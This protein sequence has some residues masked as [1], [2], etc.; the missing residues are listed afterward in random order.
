MDPPHQERTHQA[1]I[2][3]TATST[4]NECEMDPSTNLT[5][6]SHGQKKRK[7]ATPQNTIDCKSQKLQTSDNS[8]IT[9]G[10]RMTMEKMKEGPMPVDSLYSTLPVGSD[11]HNL[12]IQEPLQ[13][14]MTSSL[15]PKESAASHLDVLLKSPDYR[16]PRTPERGVFVP[17]KTVPAILENIHEYQRHIT[18]FNA[19]EHYKKFRFTNL[20]CLPSFQE[21]LEAV[22]DAIQSLL[23]GIMHDVGL[24]DCVQLRLEGDSLTKSINSLQK[25]RKEINAERFLSY[26]A[27]V[28]QSNS[29]CLGSS[30]LT[31]TVTIVSN[32]YGGGK[33]RRS[34]KSICFSKIIEK[35]R[36]WLF[37]FQNNK[38]CFAASLIALLEEGSTDQQLLE[39]AKDLH[40][41]LGL[42]ENHMVNFNDI[43]LFETQLNVTINVLYYGQDQE[44]L[45]FFKGKV[46]WKD[47]ILYI[48]HHEEHYYGIKSIKSFLGADYFCK[49]CQSIFYH[50][51]NHSCKD[52]CKAC[53][54]RTCCQNQG[55]LCPTCRLFCRSEECLANHKIQA[56]GGKVKCKL[57]ACCE[58]CH[59]YYKEGSHH[60]CQDEKCRVC[61]DTI[62][63]V[64]DHLCYMTPYKVQEVDDNYIVYDIECTQDNQKHIPNYIY[65]KTLDGEKSWEF[66]DSSC[67]V[68]F[69]RFFADTKFK[70]YTFIA[71]NAGK[72]DS[73]F[74]LRQLIREKLEVRLMAKGGKLICVTVVALKIR[75]IDSINFLPMKLSKLPQA[76]GFAEVKG[77]FPHFFNTDDNQNYVGSLPPIEKYGADYMMPQEKEEFLKWHEEQK[78][79]NEVFDFQ[80]EL[81]KYC[82]QDVEILRQACICFRKRV[83]EMTRDAVDPFQ[84]PTLAS[85]CMAMYRFS[86][87]PAKTIAILPNDRYHRTK[88]RFSTPAIQWLMYVS[89]KEKINIQ[90]ALRGGEKKVGKYFLDGYALINDVHTAFEFLGCIYHGCPTCF[91][92]VVGNPIAKSKK[93]GEL[94]DKYERK[95]RY[96]ER[97]KFQVRTLWEHDW[98]EMVKND[99]EVK[100]FLSE[101]QYPQPLEPRDALYGGRTNVIKLY[102]K[103]TPGETISYYDFTS[104]YPFVNKTKEYPIRHPEIIYQDFK[105]IKEYF[106]IAKVKVYPPKELFFPVLP[107]K[108]N[109]KLMFPLCLTCAQNVAKTQCDHDDEERSITGTWCTIEIQLA[110]EK[111]Y[112]IAKIY[113]IWHFSKTSDSLFAQ[114]IELH[115]RDKQEA[116][117]FPVWCTNEEKKKQYIQDYKKRE[118]ISLRPDHICVNTAKRQISKLFLNSLWG[119]FGQRTNL[120]NTSIVMKSD[121]FMHYFFH[122]LYDVSSLDFID[123]ETA[124]V[125]WQYS[126]ESYA[127]ENKNTNIFIACFT[128]AYARLELFKLLDALQE[129]CLY[130]DTDS[131][132]F[133]SKEGDYMPPLGDYL[134]DLTS[135]IPNDTYITEF[136]S[137]GP[138]TYG[139]KLSNGETTIKVKG[140][141]LNCTAK[142]D[143]NFDS[144]KELVLDYPSNPGGESQKTIVVE[145]PGIVRR[146]KCWEIETRQLWKT[147]KCV[148][149]KR[150][151]PRN[152]D[153]T[154]LPF[155]YC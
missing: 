131:V 69:V 84:C 70:K 5:D 64:E 86:F 3:V 106:G 118:G 149:T 103:V 18:K 72:Y 68:D 63:K 82:K 129:R 127:K 136:V 121:D 14:T 56:K 113:E 15:V 145:Q 26:F 24:Q 87:L 128:T 53:L 148:Y 153:F 132:I 42:P 115:L 36:R 11:D 85:L 143:I 147:Q 30:S 54:R 141:T 22:H 6:A 50:K 139:Y 4:V 44:R 134:G 39:K 79:K 92:S 98:K 2:D 43:A 78:K 120:P 144:L 137:A 110:V 45:Q 32:N 104:L 80:V 55:I 94:Y 99:Q 8:V 112:R 40:E 123:E 119:K 58:Q 61:L 111:G 96:L 52:F 1:T 83:M 142:K 9:L 49:Y 102:H 65:A 41:K 155:G 27:S 105:D 17:D 89:Y 114:Y 93:N 122:S 77:F 62:V 116:S 38:L 135:E 10:N 75:F 150:H 13:D 97:C 66:K 29:D 37:D 71:H 108:V 12:T 57:K 146:K 76:L 73:Y 152:Q 20:D 46:P 124:M 107:V 60:E 23:D 47:E 91:N 35:K 101:M 140:I 16:P 90:H 88:K 109:G 126:K 19:I 130:H 151:F 7:S 25:N 74:I 34:L 28:L 51:N 154:T 117:G 138:K 48:L 21:V 67:L 133:V 31:L 33:K 95:K 100:V 81:K 125:N 59:H